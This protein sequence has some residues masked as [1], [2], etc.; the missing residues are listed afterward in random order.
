MD[1]HSCTCNENCF[2]AATP[3][4]TPWFIVLH[5]TS[6]KTGF[7]Q[8]LAAAAVFAAPQSS[9][10]LFCS[11]IYTFADSPPC[12]SLTIFD[13]GIE[14][15]ANQCQSVCVSTSVT[16]SS[17][18]F[19]H[20]HAGGRSAIASLLP[21]KTLAIGSETRP[22]QSGVPASNTLTQWSTLRCALFSWFLHATFPRTGFPSAL[23][24]L[25]AFA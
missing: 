11:N 20:L 25:T 2:Q 19:F 8:P 24:L 16:K 7:L 6:P 22:D 3:L 14:L 21:T 13:L 10:K 1:A 4:S 9:E 17:F 15:T 5:A 23:Q 18:S 12:R